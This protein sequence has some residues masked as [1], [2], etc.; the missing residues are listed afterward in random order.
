MAFII[1]YPDE[2]S[3]V[4]VIGLSGDSPVSIN[5][6][7]LCE[8]AGDGFDMQGIHRF[9][10]ADRDVLFVIK[11]N[12]CYTYNGCWVTELGHGGYRIISNKDIVFEVRPT[13]NSPR[14]PLL[15][16]LGFLGILLA[17]SIVILKVC[18]H[19]VRHLDDVVYDINE[20]EPDNVADDKEEP[21]VVS[22]P[23][24]EKDTSFVSPDRFD[25]RDNV[26]MVS[27]V[28]DNG[29]DANEAA[30]IEET[31][32][33]QEADTT[34]DNADTPDAIKLTNKESRGG[35][36]HHSTV[37]KPLTSNI[38]DGFSKWKKKGLTSY[39]RFYETGHNEERELAIQFFRKAL[40]YKKDAE[41]I[42][43]INLLEEAK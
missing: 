5:R 27:V 8:I 12:T 24:I 33:G 22:L 39:Q 1:K 6:T 37:D 11:K 32:T 4:L 25:D 7:S 18:N 10:P 38:D 16:V 23:P 31:Q 9:F 2:N 13:S 43:Y 21:N 35:L 36:S 30:H 29:V 34:G 20:R 42:K 28:D 3:P 40:E 41:V 14:F 19:N 15:R 17:V 26:D